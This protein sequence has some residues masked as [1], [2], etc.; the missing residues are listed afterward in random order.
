M[1][2]LRV[3]VPHEEDRKSHKENCDHA[4]RRVSAR[5]AAP[6][7]SNPS[8]DF[9]AHT[10]KSRTMSTEAGMGLHAGVE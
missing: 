7:S 8:T 3:F 2:Q 9:C 10:Q 6:V 4:A 5:I 1:H